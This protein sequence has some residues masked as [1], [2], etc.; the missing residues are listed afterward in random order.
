MSYIKNIS[1]LTCLSLAATL[2]F[3]GCQKLDKPELGNYPK[4][5]NPPGGPLN[6]YVA[7]DGT[8]SSPSMNAVDSIR[9]NF[10]ADNPLTSV[11][12]ISGKA[13]KGEAK[14]YVKYAKPNDWALKAESF[15]VSFWAKGNGQTL[16]NT[17][18]NGPESIFAFGSSHNASDWPA[19][20]FLLFEG[21]NTA[22]AIKFYVYAANGTDKWFVWEG[23]N[24][25]PGLRDN[26]WHHYAFSYNASTSTMTLYIDGVANPN[27]STWAGHGKINIS[28]ANITELR[29]G[30]GPRDDG[31]ADGESGWMQSSWKGLLDQFR[32][33]STALTATEVSA[34]Y[35][36]KK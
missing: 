24:M 34:L 21:N 25:I 9:A 16:N 28:N 5:A 20:T 30:R 2:L 32:M 17:G 15:T 12:G 13:I 33:Y 4:D 11:D 23:G 31:D 29:I 18:G 27:V 1:C 7:F 22:C 14:K 10:P 19:T 26:N 8:T 6:F 35:T 36:G 3:S